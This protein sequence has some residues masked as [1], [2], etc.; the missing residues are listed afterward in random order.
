MAFTFNGNI[1]GAIKFNGNDVKKLIYNG[2]TVW[3][4]DITVLYEKACAGQ[5]INTDPSFTLTTT[6]TSPAYGSGPFQYTLKIPYQKTTSTA[7]TNQAY[8]T[9]TLKNSS[10]DTVQTWSRQLINAT[11]GVDVR[12]MTLT[13]TSD[14]W[15]GEETSFTLSIDATGS[16]GDL[17]RY[18]SGYS[19]T[20]TATNT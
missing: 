14:T 19:I 15:L 11:S 18:P 2:V 6:A 13:W 1:P 20:L 17:V 5:K 4:H 12:Y 9:P 8:L 7:F 16:N 3:V 10:G